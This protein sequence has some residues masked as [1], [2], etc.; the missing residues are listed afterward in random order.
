ME[1]EPRKHRMRAVDDSQ[2]L[3]VKSNATTSRVDVPT[4]RL[5]R[6][7]QGQDQGSRKGDMII[8]NKVERSFIVVFT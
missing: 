2:V 8:A 1:S 4:A 5:C 7:R 3:L 6:A